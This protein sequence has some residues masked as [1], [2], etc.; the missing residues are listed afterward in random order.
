MGIRKTVPGVQAPISLAKHK[1]KGKPNNSA[2]GIRPRSR[3]AVM[4][5]GPVGGKS[6]RSENVDQMGWIEGIKVGNNLFPSFCQ[7]AM[8]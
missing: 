3:D 2:P 6:K 1:V 8:T 5:R 7:I 4:T